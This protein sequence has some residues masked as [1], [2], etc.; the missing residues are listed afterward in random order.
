MWPDRRLLDLFKIEVPIVQAPM[1]GVQDAD[2]MIGAA[3]GGALASLPCPMISVEKA[4][5]QINI[6]RQRISAP[7]NMNFFCHQAVDADAEREAIWRRRLAPY[8]KELGLDPNAQIE[9]ANRAPFGQ[10]MCALVEEL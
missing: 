8:F 9:A 2:V 7:V 1:A 4:R 3:Q 6:F 5:E 10:E